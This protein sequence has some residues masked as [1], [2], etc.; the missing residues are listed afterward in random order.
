MS[1]HPLWPRSP[2][3]ASRNAA[4]QEARDFIL[5]YNGYYAANDLDRYFAVFDPQLTQWW[6]EG[7]VDLKTYETMWRKLVANGGGTS[8][9]VVTDLQV[10]VDPAGDA[11]VATYIL[12][13][14]PRKDGQARGRGGA[15][16][17]NR[18]P[19]QARGEWKI[20]HV[21]YGPAK[22]SNNGQEPRPVIAESIYANPRRRHRSRPATFASHPMHR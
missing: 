13:V 5:R 1:R 17:G 19:L 12:E 11:A 20:V 22:P 14:T 8:N 4:E 18:R 7:R 9:A 2:Q 15:E 3:A 21:N 16:S 10:Q 6:P